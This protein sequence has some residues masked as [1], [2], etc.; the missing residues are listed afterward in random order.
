MI[1]PMAGGG[2]H[3][4]LPG[5]GLKSGEHLTGWSGDGRFLLVQTETPI[6]ARVYRVDVQTGEKTLWKEISPSEPSGV[7]KI[8]DVQFT[9]DEAGYAYGYARVESSNLYLVEGLPE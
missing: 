7:I 4:A 2:T 5:P 9:A 1:G 3:W 8:R 6:P